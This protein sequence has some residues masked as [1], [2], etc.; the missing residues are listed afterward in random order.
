[1]GVAFW[2]KTN[3]MKLIEMAAVDTD[4][5]EIAKA[6]GSTRKLIIGKLDRMAQHR[7]PG[8]VRLRA[9]A[10]KPVPGLTLMDLTNTTCRWPLWQENTPGAQR[11]FCGA[12]TPGIDHAQPYCKEHTKKA[13]QRTNPD[14]RVQANYRPYY[15]GEGR[16]KETR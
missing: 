4:P 6:L 10:P 14:G 16:F 1:M 2:N 11:F 13:Y 9:R 12:Y 7:K 3:T 8:R 5:A 15:P